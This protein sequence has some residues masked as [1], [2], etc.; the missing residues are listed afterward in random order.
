M[1]PCDGVH[2]WTD[3]NMIYTLILQ[4]PKSDWKAYTK[5]LVVWLARVLC[6]LFY[7]YF[8]LDVLNVCNIRSARCCFCRVCCNHVQHSMSCEVVS[9]VLIWLSCLVNC[10]LMTAPSTVSLFR[11]N[12][13]FLV[14]VPDS[15]FLIPGVSIY[16]TLQGKVPS[17][18]WLW[19]RLNPQPT[20][21][22]TIAATHT[23][24]ESF[25]LHMVDLGL[26]VLLFVGCLTLQQ[27]ANV[28]QRQICSDNFTCSH[29]EIEVADQTVYLTQSQH[30]DTGPTS[31]STDPITPGAWQGSHWSANF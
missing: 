22:W 6:L 13:V 26:T 12:K 31:P 5:S 16:V 30:T 29:T 27:H 11:D 25:V 7:C 15:N 24:T 3:E 14:L 17:A 10:S 4:S 19:G 23:E 9:I 2:A 28:S 20:I 18:G 8:E 1:S 21:S